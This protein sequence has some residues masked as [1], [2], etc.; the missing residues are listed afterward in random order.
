[1]NEFLQGCLMLLLIIT[2]IVLLATALGW[3]FGVLLEILVFISPVLLAVA[4]LY[5][6]YLLLRMIFG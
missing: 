3:L 1:M 4:A 6:G 5:G 2:L